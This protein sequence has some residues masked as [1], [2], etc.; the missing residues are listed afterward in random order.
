MKIRVSKGILQIFDSI[1]MI[2]ILHQ[3]LVLPVRYNKF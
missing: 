3:H 1:D 2:H